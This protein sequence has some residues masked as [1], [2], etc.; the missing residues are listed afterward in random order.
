MS[1]MVRADSSASQPYIAKA[2]FSTPEP[3]V[4]LKKIAIGDG[5]LGLVDEGETLPVVRA[6]TLSN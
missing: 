3:P 5:T 6:S 1:H 4:N 2:I